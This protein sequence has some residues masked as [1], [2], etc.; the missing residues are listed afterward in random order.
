MVTHRYGAY[1]RALELRE[2][3]EAGA[4]RLAINRETNM[5]RSYGASGIIA[6]DFVLDATI[7]AV[8]AAAG[9]VSEADGAGSEQ[10][11]EALGSQIDMLRDLRGR[12]SSE[13]GVWRLPGGEEFYAQTLQFQLGARVEPRQAHAQALE[14]ARALQAEAD[15]LLRGDGLVRGDVAS[16]L[17]A[18]ATDP[19]HLAADD[20]AKAL[21]VDEMNARLSRVRALLA[22]V[23]S[24]G[25]T[26]AGAVERL[27]PSTENDGAQGRR[28]GS[29]Y[30]IDLGA[31][32]PTWT[33]PSVVH[34]EVSPGHL[35]QAQYERRIAVPSLQARYSSGY[36]EG[37]ATYAEQLADDIGAYSDDPLGGIGYLQWMLFRVARIVADTGIHVMRW[38]RERAIEEMR[39]LQG[40]SIA[41]VSIED[42]VV[43]LCAQPGASAA[44]G[45]AALYIAELRERTRRTTRERFSMTAFHDAMLRHGPLSPPGLEQAARAA[46][47]LS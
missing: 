28:Q 30:L 9:G 20:A 13:A 33:L 8:E 12:A 42:D 41:F 37:W 15:V 17:R 5:L 32:R 2:G 11:V 29:R 36:S 47:A 22:G 38:S 44:Q 26:V 46:F 27:D 10:L 35:L 3:D 14:R 18:L 1:R 6:P 34:H 39:A 7:P 23:I 24:D 43:R 40:D 16:R 25:A 31:P 19:R 45:L 4:I 21:A